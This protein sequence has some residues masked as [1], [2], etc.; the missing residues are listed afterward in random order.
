LLGMALPARL[1]IIGFIGLWIGGQINRGIYRLAWDQRSI[2][3]WSLP[4]KKAP[5]RCWQDRLPVIGW[6]GLRRESVLHGPGYWIR[7]L[8]IELIT[9]VGLAALYWWE[10][11]GHLVPTTV[12]WIDSLAE[13]SPSS[14]TLL[15]ATYL[16]H[17]VLAC[18]MLVASVIDYDEK[19]IPD[20]IT[21]PGT[22]AGLLFAIVLPGSHL[23]V[24]HGPA[25]PGMG[26]TA[27]P[28]NLTSN[29]LSSWPALL[30]G[31]VGL[32]IGL[33]CF[34][35][36]CFAMMPRTWWT[37]SGM[38]KTVQYLLASLFRQ[39][40]WKRYAAML[41]VGWAVIGAVWMAGDT[42]QWASLLSALVGMAFGA[43]LVWAIRAIGG[44]ALSAEAMGFGDVTLLAMI[45]ATLGWQAA[46]LVFFIAP[47][48]SVVI[49]VLQMLLTG[50]KEIWF[51]PFLSL[52][53]LLVIINWANLWQRFAEIFAVGWLVPIA[54]VVCLV[55]MGLML[56]GLRGIRMVFS[57]V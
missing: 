9:G 19:T 32:A 10:T 45:G 41:V 25:S 7:P 11:T 15:H 46:M 47:L 53:A 23:P 26:P 5:P 21:L 24:P 42:A 51:G 27:E 13:V 43:A 39:P 17:A 50:R 31:G 40:I 22:I 49:A 36:W 1:L 52:A 48:L 54:L 57:R 44:A 38:L 2:G 28:L 55:L 3:P 14:V 6:F 56:L 33:L 29:P 18:L 37:R 30:S 8:V 12:F 16:P 34:A 35:F 4:D 20:A